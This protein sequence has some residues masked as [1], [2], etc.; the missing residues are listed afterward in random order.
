MWRLSLL[1]VAVTSLATPPPLGLGADVASI[2]TLEAALEHAPDRIRDLQNAPL[3]ILSV[4]TPYDGE[5]GG[6]ARV[7]IVE[8]DH[9][10]K[11]AKISYVRTVESRMVPWILQ[12]EAS[13]A[14]IAPAIYKIIEGDALVSLFAEHAVLRSLTS[15]WTHSP[16]SPPVSMV[17]MDLVPDGFNFMQRS[18]STRELD[19]YPAALL[20]VWTRC[21]EAIESY[22][23][24]H[25]VQMA[26][27]Q[28]LIQP[29]GNVMVIDFD[30]YTFTDSQGRRWAY[31]GITDYPDV[32]YWK[33]PS[34]A[35]K[36]NDL[37]PNVRALRE[38]VAPTTPPAPSDRRSRT[39]P[40]PN[41]RSRESKS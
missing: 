15:P 2:R 8:T 22:L 3:R 24:R 41:R 34:P 9:G 27:E 28:F 12:D 1:L 18:R 16:Q 39:V 32:D 33:V 14:G 36:L 6:S 35:V 11:L 29:D 10:T 13:R 40:S 21:L 30:H 38:A 7:V 20:P 19:R 23:N 31:R 5:P 37:T 25:N 17:V 4:K 26:D